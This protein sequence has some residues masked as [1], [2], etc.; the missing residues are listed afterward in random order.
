MPLAC[1]ILVNQRLT[2]ILGQLSQ[3]AIVELSLCTLSQNRLMKKPVEN[4]LLFAMLL[5]TYLELRLNHA[6]NFGPA[7]QATKRR[8]VKWSVKIANGWG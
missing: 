8:L 4:A 2:N 6:R 7:L 3:Q 5:I 1:K